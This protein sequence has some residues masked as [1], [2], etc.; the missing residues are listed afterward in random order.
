MLAILSPATRGAKELPSVEPS[1]T[2]WS[3][4][5]PTFQGKQ[6]HSSASSLPSPSEHSVALYSGL[7]AR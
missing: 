2:R 5:P 1:R 3:L 7:I 4:L 6:S